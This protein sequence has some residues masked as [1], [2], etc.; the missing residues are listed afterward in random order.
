MAYFVNKAG[1]IVE[2][3]EKDLPDLQ[4]Q[5]L[6]PASDGDI[7]KHNLQVDYDEKTLGG[8]ALELANT[9]AES[10]GRAVTDIGELA[11]TPGAMLQEA[12]TGE[13]VEFD[14]SK[15][16]IAEAFTPEARQRAEIHPIASTAGTIAATAPAMAF[17]GWGG[18]AA[19]SLLS[20][21]AFEA[22]S[23]FQQNRQKSIENVAINT[24]IGLG[25]GAAAM[26]VGKLTEGGWNFAR[27]LVV[28][29]EENASKAGARAILDE[30]SQKE[31]TQAGD[32]AETI[33]ARGEKDPGVQYLYKER[34]GLRAD[35]AGESTKAAQT[36]LDE[37]ENLASMRATSDELRESII[38]N[39]VQ[40]AQAT[41]AM[42]DSLQDAL[43]EIKSAG[44][45]SVAKPF[46]DAVKGLTE[47]ADPTKWFMRASETS[48]ALVRAKQVAL[49]SGSQIAIEAVDKAQQVFRQGLE[50]SSIWGQAADQEASRFANFSRRY[51]DHIGDFEEHFTQTL[52]GKRQ[53]SVS[54]FKDFLQDGLDSN[55][56]PRKSLENMLDSAETSAEFAQ[57]YGRTEQ[58]ARL[59]EAVDT[60]RKSL[61]Q[62]DAI[63]AA[64][65]TV[66]KAAPSFKQK[67]MDFGKELAV[68][69]AVDY[70]A[71]KVFGVLPPGLSTVARLAKRAGLFNSIGI[72]AKGTE[73]LAKQSV[74]RF[75]S[76]LTTALRTTSELA[77]RSAVPVSGLSIA[78]FDSLSKHIRKMAKDPKYF[79][80]VM[81][82][83]FG[84]M[85]ETAP[86]VYS[87]LSAQTA[88]T[89]AF[90]ST[91]LPQT[92]G[93]GPFAESIPVAED[94]LYEFDLYYSACMDPTS[95]Y[96]SLEKGDLTSQQVEAFQ[97]V[98]PERYKDLQLDVFQKLQQMHD[99]GIEVE[100]Q[101]REQLDVLFD[102]D[103]GGDPGMTWK[104]AL[105]SYDAQQMLTSDKP[106]MPTALPQASQRSYPGAIQTLHNGAAAVS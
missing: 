66:S 50:D 4:E 29:G 11:A 53:A 105:Q 94:E 68:D 76:P 63:R 60:I 91:K 15:G 82:N 97:T 46:K 72:M 47:G 44:V 104:V 13:P 74:Q 77:E 14:P 43:G 40:Q 75:M 80:D 48:D 100:T 49:D 103:G 22:E 7:E 106:K 10:F 21:N 79:G 88:K 12:I 57:K 33:A 19:E 99:D 59:T 30:V 61:R 93:G 25:T 5:G 3:D 34:K 35:I 96:Q 38:D 18:L 16:G 92:S 81:A 55:G 39:S 65:E 1:T 8:K 73:T 32:T 85:P 102:L 67:A 54:K 69:A 24:L 27:N 26:G 45:P 70:T 98:Y 20:G 23:A 95:V 64:E 41:K 90:L 86:E 36:M 71:S 6:R 2:A 56:I 89:F 52:Q 58:A 101:T 62:G 17:G 31:A 84:D 28:E 42:K 78:G 51:G 9:G 83:N 87:A 37:Y